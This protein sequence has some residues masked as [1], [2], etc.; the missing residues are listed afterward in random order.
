MKNGDIVLP[1][2]V[3]L[4]MKKFENFDMKN[5]KA[6]LR[7]TLNMR[8]KFAGLKKILQGMY[9]EVQDLEEKCVEHVKSVMAHVSEEI[10]LRVEE[11][12]MLL[13]TKNR[14]V[15]KSQIQSKDWLNGPKDMIFFT[16]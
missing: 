13:E 11:E 3:A 12:E 1:F 15:E 6:D 8:V 9:P 4:V 10:K 7:M 16:V 5:F 2:S 14:N